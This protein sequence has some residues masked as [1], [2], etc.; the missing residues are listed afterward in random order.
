MKRVLLFFLLLVSILINQQFIFAS[1]NL[2]VNLN[3]QN[4]DAIKADEFKEI[5]NDLFKERA[6][7]WNSMFSDETDL[8]N[9][10]KDLKNIVAKP[11]LEYDIESFSKL[12]E[13]CTDMDKIVDVDVVSIENINIKGQKATADIEVKWLMENLRQTYSE[14]IAYKIELIKECDRWKIKDYNLN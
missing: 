4:I 1:E 5:I 12:K 14:K 7:L 8:E 10:K 13:E 2:N 11:L 9:V 6:K 3:K